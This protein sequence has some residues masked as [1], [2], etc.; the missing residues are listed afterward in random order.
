MAVDGAMDVVVVPFTP[1]TKAGTLSNVSMLRESF[2][3]LDIW[4]NEW[5][6]AGLVEQ[7]DAVGVQAALVCA[8]VGTGWEVS[9]EYIKAMCDEVP[10]RILANAGIDPRDVAGGVRRLEHAVTELGFV[11][12]HSYPHWFGLSPADRRYYPF[13]WKCIELDVPVQIQVGQAFQTGLY[14]VGRPEAI[15]AMAVELPDLKIVCIHTAY[16]WDR[17]MVSVAWKHPNVYIG[18]DCWLPRDWAPELIDFIRGEGREKVLWGTNHPVLQYADM[19]AGVEELGLDEETER[20]LL[21]DNL[22]RVYRL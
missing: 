4:G 5:T 6:A 10:G 16:P 3:H 12:A 17:E 9:Y 20:L 7:M 1:E 11:G 2:E 21:R 22:K 13:Y 15:D 19:L 18:A 8:I 14:N